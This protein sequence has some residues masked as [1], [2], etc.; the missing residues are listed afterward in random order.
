MN[1]ESD[2][3]TVDNT[4]SYEVLYNY[5]GNDFKISVPDLE[6]AN[7]ILNGMFYSSTSLLFEMYLCYRS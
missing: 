5:N 7:L 3:D 2:Q 1:V 4:T 6:T